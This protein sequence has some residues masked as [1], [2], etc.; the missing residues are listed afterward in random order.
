MTTTPCWIC[1]SR[2]GFIFQKRVLHRYDVRYY[3][4]TTC[5][6]LQTETPYWLDDAYREPINAYDV[7]AVE[8]NL[9]TA[10]LTRRLLSGWFDPNQQFVDYGGGTGLFVRLM[11]DAGYEFFR[12]D[13][14][15]PNIYAQ[16]FDLSDS[17]REQGFG[18]VTAFELLE[19]TTRPTEDFRVISSLSDSFFFST[20]L[21]PTDDKDLANWVYLAPYCGQHV[22]FFTHRSLQIVAE[23][24][25]CFLYTNNSN[26]HLLTPR[27]LDINIG[28]IG[29]K[30]GRPRNFMRRLLRKLDTMISRVEARRPSLYE[31][32]LAVVHAR[33]ERL[34]ASTAQ[35]IVPQPAAALIYTSPERA[36]SQAD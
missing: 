31:H 36:A 14:F 32:D 2:A 16:G 13:R 28:Q 34:N 27:R 6:F 29:A 26:L 4:C 23:R 17:G 12:H 33:A 3:K 19:H 20:L 10:E 18:L 8:R 35:E 30:D 25:H 1:D 9:W 22:S 21:Q 11:R 15:C 24:L 7:G 5:G